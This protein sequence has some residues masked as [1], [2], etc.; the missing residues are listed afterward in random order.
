MDFEYSLKMKIKLVN[1]ALE[2][3]LA[4]KYPDKIYEAM[5]Y[6]MFAG[7]KRVRPVLIFSACEAICGGYQEAVPFACAMEMIHTCSLIHDDLP[8]MDNDD[9]RRGRL[10]SHKV[11][12]D[13]FAILAGDGLL[14]K[15]YEIMSETAAER[16]EKKVNLAMK[17]VANA[18]GV[19]GMIG[20]QVVDIESENKSIDENTLLYIHNNKTG[21]LIEA[22][23]LCGGL[24]GGATQEQLEYLSVIG[25]KIGLAFQ[26]KDDILDVTGNPEIL[27]KPINSDEKNCKT[28]YVTL[29]GLEKAEAEFNRLSTEALA[30]VDAFA[31]NGA[32]LK[33]Y[34]TKLIYRDK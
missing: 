24:I 17:V 23:L 26:I 11:F 31:E 22:S 20:G 7:G 30:L 21:A 8:A 9:Y 18:A 29:Y 33:Q 3:Y 1:S 14:N 4:P 25:K 13:G 2:T 27:G 19:N 12:G 34:A 16:N 5:N 6:S 15:A 32:F 10:T 28:T